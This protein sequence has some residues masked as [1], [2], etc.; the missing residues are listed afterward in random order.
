M[1]LFSK[2][3]FPPNVNAVLVGN[4]GFKQLVLDLCES[5]C[6][7]KNSGYINDSNN[8]ITSIK[9]F[10]NNDRSRK[11][12]TLNITNFDEHN[13]KFK[14]SDSKE[15]LFSDN[16][17]GAANYSCVVV[18]GKKCPSAF[19]SVNLV[20]R[21]HGSLDNFFGDKT[22]Y[23]LNY[24]PGLFGAPKPWY[25]P[26]SSTGFGKIHRS[27][28]GCRQVDLEIRYLLRL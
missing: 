10:M 8:K 24:K 6:T 19:K 3:G 12:K 21:S 7:N 5:R 13:L 18:S 28:K 27:V 22:I 17:N 16:N 9:F 4:H 11:L 23:N 25:A 2:Q 14:S 20:S 26:V 15:Y 1:P